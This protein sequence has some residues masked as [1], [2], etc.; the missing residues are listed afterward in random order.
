MDYNQNNSLLVL[1]TNYGYRI[2]DVVNNFQL[3]ST[4]DDSQKDLGPLKLCKILYKSPLLG[5]IGAKE[6][7][8]LKENSLYMF[9]L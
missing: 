6:N 1:G 8:R 2:F 7:Q 4:V 5:F 3:L 9:I